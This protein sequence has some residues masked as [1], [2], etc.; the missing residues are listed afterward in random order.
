MTEYGFFSVLPPVLALA[1]AIFTRQ[2]YVSLFAGIWLGHTILLGFEPIGA[3]VGSV[4]ALVEVFEDPGRTKIILL[5]AM[6]GAFLTFTQ[7]S[8]GMRGLVDWLTQRGFATTQRSA[9]ILAW[10]IGTTL[11]MKPMS[12]SMSRDRYRGRSSTDFASHARSSLIFSMR[13]LLPSQRSSPSIP[14]APIS[15]AC[16][17]HRTSKTLYARSRARCPSI[18]SVTNASGFMFQLLLG[19]SRDPKK[20]SIPPS[21]LRGLLRLIEKALMLGASKLGYPPPLRREKP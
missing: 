12:A 3:L 17:R 20:R 6:I 1:L 19:P 5:S 2:V 7:Y 8:G 4:D 10:G 9:G 14:G 18:S 13:P 21:S 16:S 15:S 11:F